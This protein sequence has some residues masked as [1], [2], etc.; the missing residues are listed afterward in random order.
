MQPAERIRMGVIGC[1]QFMRRQHLQTI[2]RSNCLCLTH[3]ADVDPDSLAQVAARYRPARS[4][5]QWQAVVADPEVDVVVV[6][7]VPQ[8]HPQI[9]RAALEHGKPV[10]VEKPLAPT[11]AQGRTIQRLAA[12]RN[13]PVAVGFNRRFAPATE[14]LSKAFRAVDR[15]VSVFY[16]ISDDDRIRPPAQQW[17]RADRLLIEAV[18]IFDLLAYLLRAEPVWVCARETRPNDATVMIDFD[19]GSRATVLCSSHGS[20]AQAKEHLEAVLDHAAVEMNDYFEFRSYGLAELPAL[21]HFAGRPYDDCDNGHVQD[22]ARRGCA[23]L[24]QLRRRYHQLMVDSGVLDDSSNA[25]AW[26]RANDLLGNPPLPQVNYAADK[27]WGR[28]LESFCVAAMT[29]TTS[30][31]ANAVDGNRATACAVAAR[32]SIA[33]GRPVELDPQTWLG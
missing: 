27:G 10:Y 8:W 11:V 13:L 9:C 30:Q 28:A 29:G 6:G 14:W 19:R 25:A 3:V 31:Y 21:R 33:T 23:A 7:V 20:L 17:K 32:Q 5:T 24:R 1:G 12:G 4:S 26:A 15:P 16:R 22:F 2:G 18:H